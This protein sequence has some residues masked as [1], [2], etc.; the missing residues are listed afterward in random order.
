MIGTSLITL[1]VFLSETCLPN[2]ARSQFTFGVA[3]SSSVFGVVW[4]SKARLAEFALLLT[5]CIYRYS[6]N[7]AGVRESAA[8]DVK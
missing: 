6:R 7:E 1:L 2:S 3:K 8:V 5:S 4:P